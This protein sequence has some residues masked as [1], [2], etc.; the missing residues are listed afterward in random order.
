MDG[1][2][3]GDEVALASGLSVVIPEGLSASKVS[4]NPGGPREAFW[5]VDNTTGE[6]PVSVRALSAEDLREATSLLCSTSWPR[7]HQTAR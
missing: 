2:Q 1:Y 5:L 6:I 3:P 7:A 4:D